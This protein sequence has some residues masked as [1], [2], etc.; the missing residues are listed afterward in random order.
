MALAR[1]GIWKETP[2]TG[3]I[4]HSDTQEC[5]GWINLYWIVKKYDIKIIFYVNAKVAR[6]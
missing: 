4:M 1:R 2:K 5:T 6:N 3:Q